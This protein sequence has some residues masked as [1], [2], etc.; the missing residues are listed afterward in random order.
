MKLISRSAVVTR[1]TR[2]FGSSPNLSR[3][4]PSPIG[5]NV[6][7]ATAVSFNRRLDAI[8]LDVDDSLVL[9]RT[10]CAVLVFAG[11][12]REVPYAFPL[13]GRIQVDQRYL[14]R[15]EHLWQRTS[16]PDIVTKI[17]VFAAEQ[18]GA[19]KPR[20]LRVVKITQDLSVYVLA[21]VG[22]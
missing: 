5:K 16:G 8:V 3:R 4:S 15:C 14:L 20:A 7:S 22:K 9:V 2:K 1:V 10:G 17:I 21:L 6:N 11:K 19:E 13:A 12:M 18:I